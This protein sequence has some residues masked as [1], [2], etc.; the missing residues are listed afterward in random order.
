M[1]RDLPTGDRNGGFDDGVLVADVSLRAPT[2]P[3]SGAP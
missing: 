1:D 3:R 2:T